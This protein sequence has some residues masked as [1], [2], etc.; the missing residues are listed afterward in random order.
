MDERAYPFSNCA[1]RQP[2]FKDAAEPAFLRSE[3]TRKA[4]PYS[5]GTTGPHN[6]SVNHDRAIVL[7]RMKFHHYPASHRNAL[8][9]AHVT[10][11]EGQVGQ[12]PSDDDALAG[13][14][15]WANLC[16]VLD[17]DSVIVAARICFDAAEKGRESVRT[18]LAPDRIDS[19][20]TE[21]T[22]GDTFPRCQPCFGCPASRTI[23][24]MHRKSHGP[25]RSASGS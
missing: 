4:E 24:R 18:E 1:I 6:G 20:G 15:G 2:Q 16:R 13:V 7:C 8:I 25:P 19:Q 23:T 9:R 11:P 3:E 21:E 10:A 5:I 17:G 14:M 22:I 12:G